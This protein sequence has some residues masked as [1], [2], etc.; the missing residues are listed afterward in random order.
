MHARYPPKLVSGEAI[1]P[2]RPNGADILNAGVTKSPGSWVQTRLKGPKGGHNNHF[3]VQRLVQNNSG[4]KDG[5]GSHRL[6]PV[7]TG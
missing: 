3:E 1:P 4:I 5:I 7:A 2:P 6:G